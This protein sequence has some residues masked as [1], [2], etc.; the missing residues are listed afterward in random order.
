MSDT[1]L[2][3]PPTFPS[4]DAQALGVCEK[5]A[6]AFSVS[7]RATD[8]ALQPGALTIG[9][10]IEVPWSSYFPELWEKYGMRTRKV[11]QMEPAELERLHADCAELEKTLL[12]LL[13][14]TRECGIP[15]GND[16]YWE[17]AFR[18]VN[19]T[20]ILV[21]QVRLL[22]RIG[23]IPRER[24]HSLH[25][26]VGS[27]PR[28]PSLYH[29]AMALEVEFVDPERIREGIALTKKPIHTGWA[30]KGFA[31]IFE[32]NASELEAGA[33]VASE[34]RMLQLPHSDADLAR[35]IHFLQWGVNAIHDN[36]R[37]VDSAQ[38]QAWRSFE[39]HAIAVLK[40]HDLPTNNWS[41]DPQSGGQQHEV[42][43]RFSRLMPRI[44]DDFH[45]FAQSHP[46][47]CHLFETPDRLGLS[48]PSCRP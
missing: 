6:Q 41:K 39:A 25:V 11:S 21:E 3:L 20:A 27:M 40:K 15:R 36:R 33:E 5:L 2:P 8:L 18:P 32:K 38:A 24:K 26:T 34:I 30:R 44:R 45:A 22:S 16:R 14:T 1:L 17:F 48:S 31:G 23:A 47:A 37:G 42:W 9:I 43:E 29:L 46:D 35:M 19:D 10:E 4:L 28:N 7:T 12:P 13:Q